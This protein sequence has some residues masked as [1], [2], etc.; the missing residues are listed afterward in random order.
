MP[1]AGIVDCH[2]HI[3][4][5]ARF[6]FAGGPGYRP[7]PDES[8]PREAFTAVLDRHG[9]SHALLIQPSGYGTDNRAML[10]AVRHADRRFKAIAV[11]DADAGER[12]LGALAEQGVVGVRFNLVSYQADGLAGPR[13]ELLLARMR[14]LDWHAQVYADDAAWPE[15]APVLRRAGVRVLID[16]CGIRDPGRGLESPGFQAVLA[17]GREGRAAVKLSGTYRIGDPALLRPFVAALLAAFGS[18]RCIWGSDWPFLAVERA[19]SYA[20]TLRTLE[21]LVEDPDLREDVLWR[22]PA[23]LFGFRSIGA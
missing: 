22:A 21:R 11:V 23:A 5:P 9:V 10:D 18:R 8:G 19:P 2:A 12:A 14:A 13:A 17:L 4:D 20:E 16:H 1:E 7:R 6:P 15:I 3:I